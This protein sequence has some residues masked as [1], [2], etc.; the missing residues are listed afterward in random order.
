[1]W[2]TFKLFLVWEG[3]LEWLFLLLLA[4]PYVRDVLEFSSQNWQIEFFRGIPKVKIVDNFNIVKHKICLLNDSLRIIF[5]FWVE[6]IKYKKNR[7]SKITN[8]IFESS[9]L[10]NVK[11]IIT[12]S[13]SAILPFC[14]NKHGGC[15]ETG[16]DWKINMVLCM[17]SF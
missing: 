13:L 12:T 7:G 4:D 8:L 9:W 6:Y 3:R 15:C 17:L 10:R 1:M 2:N 5:N 14:V 16:S 11:L